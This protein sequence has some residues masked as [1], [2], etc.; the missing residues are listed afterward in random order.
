MNPLKK[1]SVLSISDLKGYTVNNLGRNIKCSHNVQ[2]KFY[3]I[4]NK[5]KM[6]TLDYYAGK[7]NIKI[8]FNENAYDPTHDICLT[9]ANKE[10]PKSGHFKEIDMNIPLKTKEDFVNSL[11]N[12]Y[13]TVS[14][15]VKE[16][17][18]SK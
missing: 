10:Y 5:N 16:L 2:R 3:K 7:N 8:A 9:V 11:R 1:V 14:E 6:S 13:N 18:K 17:I 15:T 4:L 12:I